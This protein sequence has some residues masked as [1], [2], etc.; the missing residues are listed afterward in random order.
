MILYSLLLIFLP[1]KTCHIVNITYEHPLKCLLIEENRKYVISLIWWFFLSNFDH[2]VIVYIKMIIDFKTFLLA[3]PWRPH[4]PEHKQ[5]TK[6]WKSIFSTVLSWP[7]TAQCAASSPSCTNCMA[8]FTVWTIG[9]SV[10][11]VFNNVQYFLYSLTQ[12]CNG[13]G[14]LDLKLLPRCDIFFP[15]VVHSPLFFLGLLLLFKWWN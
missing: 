11:V 3:F 10:Y 1:D 5:I 15:I 2:F 8:V 9:K 14:I 12:Y 4:G 13:T 6:V 7:L